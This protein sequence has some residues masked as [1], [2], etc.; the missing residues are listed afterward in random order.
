MDQV[1]W[2]S[3]NGRDVSPKKY[4]L[5]KSYSCNRPEN[6]ELLG[7]KLYSEFPTRVVCNK[8]V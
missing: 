3:M 1:I 6:G 7:R 2:Q 4:T 8:V 5:T